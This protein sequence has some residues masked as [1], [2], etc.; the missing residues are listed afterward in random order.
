MNL[1]INKLINKEI[2]LPTLPAIAA[3]ILNAVNKDDA[4]LAEMG[5]V[6]S[7]D[8][9]LSAKMLRVANSGLFTCHR[10]ITDIARAMSVLGTNTIKSIALSFV[11][12]T[13]LNQRQGGGF[14]LDNFWRHAVIAAVSAE[15]LAKKLQRHTSD[16]FL[17]A[18]LHDLGILVTLLS[19][20]DDYQKLLDSEQDS[21][22]A[23]WQLERE[24]LGFDHQQVAC[25]L[26]KQWNLP[27]TVSE[28]VLY[29]H[30]P[31]EAPESHRDTAEILNLAGRIAD[32]YCGGVGA[33]KA[34]LVRASLEADYG[35]EEASVFELLDETAEKSREIIAL[36]DIDPRD[37]Q[38]YSQILQQANIEL[39]KLNL[40]NAQLILEMQ[41]AKD[42]KQRLIK[43]LQ[44]AN[45]R[46][47]EMVYLDGLTGLYNHRYFQES[48]EGELARACR[49]HASV[50]LVLFD[51][52]DFKCVNDSHGHLVGDMVLM[53]I[54][55]AVSKA[56]RANDIVARFGGDEFAIILP[57]T[58]R[59]GVKAFAEHLR[60]CVEG[61]A[62]MANGQWVN[63]TISVGA[64][65]VSSEEQP[66]SKE[67]LIDAADRG[68]YSS[69]EGGRNQVQLSR[70]T[71]KEPGA[72]LY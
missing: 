27:E 70:L 38:P 44:D 43:K 55:R 34:R 56:V 45:S 39:E 22:A 11:I 33:E 12:S 49:Y 23:L 40:C 31:E 62:T 7:V 8:P 69:K 36:F 2:Q 48:L 65:T 21:F 72:A 71:I 17:I 63:V 58:N 64:A 18:L 15:L 60:S 6:I 66:V 30:Q 9:A 52:D 53:N 25:V 13:D 42:E 67:Q 3:E 51:I 1:G 54:S 50:S 28:P 26:F 35:L 68:L 24:Q 59:E 29:H 10:E 20:G 19:K 37:L 5:K 61:I 32:I 14:N 46:L 4:A 47:K 16:I 41:E 57:A